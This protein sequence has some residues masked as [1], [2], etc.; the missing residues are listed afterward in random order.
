MKKPIAILI[1]VLTV[2]LMA[3][4]LFACNDKGKAKSER[5]VAVDEFKN[6]F[7][8]ACYDGWSYSLTSDK[9]AALPNEAHYRWQ[10]EL[11]DLYAKAL[12][13]SNIRTQ[14][15]KSLANELKTNDELK[16]ILRSEKFS[17]EKFVEVFDALSFTGADY[18]SVAA[19]VLKLW[20]SDGYLTAEK[21]IKDLTNRRNNLGV[22]VSP[23]KVTEFNEVIGELQ[24]MQDGLRTVD[25]QK[26]E[27]LSAIKVS[28]KDFQDIIEFAVDMRASLDLKSILGFENDF[29]FDELSSKTTDEIHA[30]VQSI[31][32][33]TNAF[34]ERLND[35]K[36]K[37][38]T[39]SL[40][41]LDDA[42]KNLYT[43]DSTLNFVTNTITVTKAVFDFVPLCKRLVL[44]IIN[45]VDKTLTEC[46]VSVL[47]KDYPIENYTFIVGKVFQSL[48]ENLTSKDVEQ[49]IEKL[50]RNIK[51]D[52]LKVGG[53]WFVL[54]ALIGEDGMK[55]NGSIDSV[56]SKDE[57]DVLSSLML[58]VLFNRDSFS[59]VISFDLMVKLDPSI[60]VTNKITQEITFFKRVKEAVLNDK[61]NKNKV[62]RELLKKCNE[63]VDKTGEPTV[64]TVYEWAKTIVS[65]ADLA[66]ANIANTANEWIGDALK[67][68]SKEFFEAKAD[69]QTM[70]S[71]YDKIGDLFNEVGM[72]PLKETDAKFAELQDLYKKANVEFVLK[73]IGILK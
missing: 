17:S 14:K 57:Q 20:V 25:S 55:F 68:L 21:K 7:M 58:F 64:D 69:G 30:Y 8:I 2:A 12:Y 27:I 18:A 4:C 66:F 33:A 56:L 19:E 53:A 70:K 46:A 32:G 26:Q 5:E 34:I 15:I 28:Q 10:K 38:L 67:F 51:G 39:S 41:V 36:I 62:G 61:I 9:V 23:D 71:I 40:K 31:V 13:S 63:L 1:V 52:A 48:Y 37:S 24:T 42:F 59:E 16:R 65:A 29:K 22:T 45:S 60:R 50:K 44:P 6:G 49:E 54:S 3:C 72:K 43:T 11:T 47:Y 35:A 73:F